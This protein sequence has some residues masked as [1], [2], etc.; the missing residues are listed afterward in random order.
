MPYGG[1]PATSYIDRLRLRLGDFDPV[2]EILDD[3]TYTYFYNKNEENENRT[4]RDM[5]SVML[6]A[7]S[8]FTR[9]RCADIEVYSAE[10]FNNFYKA[11]KLALSDPSLMSITITP[12]A[13]GISISDMKEKAQDSDTPNK[14]F[15]IG[16]TEGVPSY[17]QPK[18]GSCT[19]EDFYTV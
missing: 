17:D 18:D 14:M 13:G 9:E 5:L 3:A 11:V 1:S 8:R 12:W 16:M 4:F 7:L 10:R 19:V 15:Y 6:I 2:Y